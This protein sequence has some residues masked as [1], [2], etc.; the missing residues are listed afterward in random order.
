MTKKLE[1]TSAI[2]D[3]FNPETA[4]YPLMGFRKVDGVRAGH[5]HGF[6][7]GRSLDPFK[8]SALNER[9]NSAAY[10]G[11]DGEI[12]IAGVTND[13]QLAHAVE[14]GDIVPEDDNSSIC[15][16]TTGL[17]NRKTLRKGEVSLP[18]GA[19]WNL[20]D[21]LGP[22]AINLTYAERY[23]RLVSRHAADPLPYTTVLPFVWIH[24][25]AEAEAWIENC[26]ELGYEGAIFRDPKAKY[27]SGRA[28]ATANDF[29]RY[30]PVS[31]KDAIVLDFFEAM[32][33]NN[34]ATINSRGHTERSAHQE[35]KVGKGTLGGF[36]ARDV[37]TGQTV[38]IPAGRLTA[39]QRQEVWDNREQYVGRPFKYVS[40]DVGV[41][42]EPRQARWICW[43]AVEDMEKAA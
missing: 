28:T 40:L 26:L 22:E 15:S 23:D 27:K 19:I 9:F 13:F 16:L 36:I 39:P 37:A 29:W 24:S 11:C 18:D 34:E 6:F 7:H 43:R 41:K 3:E 42:D 1:L 31:D 10:A 20:F 25:P 21:Y 35:N 30:K 38:R 8:N 12:T 2:K 32:L 14:C 5:L 4:R 17:T 33:N